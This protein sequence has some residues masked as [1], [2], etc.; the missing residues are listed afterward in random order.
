MNFLATASTI[1]TSHAPFLPT[2]GV[3]IFWTGAA[4]APADKPPVKRQQAKGSE[5]IES[6]RPA[7]EYALPVVVAEQLWAGP[8]TITAKAFAEPC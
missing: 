6:V 8:A 3:R 5:G 1:Y 2:V 7:C 4:A